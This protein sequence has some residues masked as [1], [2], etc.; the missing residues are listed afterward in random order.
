MKVVLWIPL[1]LNNQRLPGK[2]TMVLNGRPLCDYVFSTVSEM[3]P[4]I[5]KYIYCSDDAIIPYIKPYYDK[6]LI[7]LQ[8]DNC[9]DGDKVKG[10]EIVERFVEDVDADIYI[11][12]HVT[13]PF[14]KRDS[15]EK[16]LNKVMS[17]DYDSA[18]SAI[19][20]QDYMWLDG[21][22]L[23]YNPTDIIRTQDMEPIYME[24]GAFF[25]FEKKVFTEMGRRIGIKPYVCEVD[26]FEAID[27]DDMNDFKFAEAV[28][29]YRDENK[30]VMI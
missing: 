4:C 21:K 3:D 14:I 9:L 25:I 28:A 5:D 18:F 16:A 23:N 27:I 12:A 22:P 20:L 11:L 17:E 26:Q 29:R 8:R 19:R 10:L 13:Q 30:D 15:I 7:Y 6:G 2:N 24:T 1:K